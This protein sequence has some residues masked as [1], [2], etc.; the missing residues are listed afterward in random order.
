VTNTFKHREA[1]LHHVAE[2][3]RPVFVA[4]G[5]PIPPNI[6]LTCGFPSRGGMAVKR[7]TIGQCWAS[8][9]S[10]DGRF[11][12]MISPVIDDPMRVAGVLAHELTHA[13]VGLQ[14]GHRGAFRRVASKIG[15]EGPMPRTIEGEAFKRKL[16]PILEA[17]GP[18]PHAELLRAGA[19]TGPKKQTTRL[20]KCKC[21]HESPDRICGYTVRVTRQWL[22]VG[23]PHCPL[24]GP[25]MEVDRHNSCA[26][27][28]L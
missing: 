28:R 6:R 11:E 5:F 14:A 22:N 26:S 15:L 23:P 3:L 13:A 27:D 25:M 8:T 9:S 16:A 17:T 10:K 19:S 7:Q 1:W 2:A 18:Y 12:I 24:H 4:A 21:R 20:I